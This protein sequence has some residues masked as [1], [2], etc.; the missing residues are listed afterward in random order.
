MKAGFMLSVGMGIPATFFYLPN[1]IGF[2]LFAMT[3]VWKI[4]LRFKIFNISKN[5]KEN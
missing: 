5:N 1:I 3:L 4:G 2:G